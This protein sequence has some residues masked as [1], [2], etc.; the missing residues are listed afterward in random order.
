MNRRTQ[1]VFLVGGL[2]VATVVVLAVALARGLD[3]H[4]CEI[5][6]PTLISCTFTW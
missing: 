4:L 6:F 5:G 1:G 2:A 3:D